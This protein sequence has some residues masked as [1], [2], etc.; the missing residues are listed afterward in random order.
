MIYILA[1]KLL[2]IA[3]SEYTK[4]MKYYEVEECHFLGYGTM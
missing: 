4:M 2:M 1:A 3:V